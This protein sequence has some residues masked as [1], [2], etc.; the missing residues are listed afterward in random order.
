MRLLDD[1][2]TRAELCRE[3]AYDQLERDH[4]PEPAWDENGEP[5]NDAAREADSLFAAGGRS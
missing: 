5:L 1:M 2:P 4:N 3:A